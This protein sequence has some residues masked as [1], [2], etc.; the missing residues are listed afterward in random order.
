MKGGLAARLRRVSKFH[1]L[2]I[3]LVFLKMLLSAVTVSQD[4]ETYANQFIAESILLRSTPWGFVNWLM[5]RLWLVLPV[6][7][8]ELLSDSENLRSVTMAS[9]SLVFV[10]KLP[11][12]SLDI[13]TGLALYFYVKRIAKTKAARTVLLAW[14]AN[15]FS[16][17][18][19]EMWGSLAV[20]P[21]SSFILMLVT[22]AWRRTS[23]SAVLGAFTFAVAP[24]L[25]LAAPVF[26]IH[27]SQARRW[28]SLL[29]HVVSALVGLGAYVRWTSDLNLDPLR[30]LGVDTPF[31]LAVSDFFAD[32]FSLFGANIGLGTSLALAYLIY[33][34]L[35][36]RDNPSSAIPIAYGTVAI[37]T[38][39]STWSLTFPLIIIP[40]L[41]LSLSAGLSKTL[42]KLALLLMALLPA[43]TI[44]AGTGPL[45]RS[46]AMFL[47][48]PTGQYKTSLGI[49]IQNLL[50]STTAVFLLRPFL[51][52]L[53]AA[54]LMAVS[55]GSRRF[56]IR[57][58]SLLDDVVTDARPWGS[59]HSS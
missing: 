36:F 23:L 31:S 58:S 4:T 22:F 47:F 15:P 28:K 42:P 59:N 48:I 55:L 3:A 57:G 30:L 16:T 56:D 7:K 8:T 40:Y 2:L 41:C 14:F 6:N 25:S 39:F 10:L 46:G 21:T 53:L 24:A 35:T 12:L 52:S 19:I 20:L 1:L 9:S 18:A 5:Y 29:L 44:I 17:L 38:A 32:P 11:A 50:E 45:F 27:L 37:L 54:A 26:W 43:W 34:Y 13:S 33:A 49:P 51:R